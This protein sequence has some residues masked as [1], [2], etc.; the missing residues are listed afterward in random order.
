MKHYQAVLIYGLFCACAADPAHTAEVS[1]RDRLIE[2]GN[3]TL[4]V[5]EAHGGAFFSTRVSTG[6]VCHDDEQCLN[7]TVSWL[8]MDGGAEPLSSDR[9]TTIELGDSG[10]RARVQF[11]EGQPAHPR[12]GESVELGVELLLG[13]R[14]AGSEA[15]T[16]SAPL[17]KRVVETR[18]TSGVVQSTQET[19]YR[20][21]G[22]II[23][24][25][26]LL[27]TS[28]L[29]LKLPAVTFQE[30]AATALGQPVAGK[31]AQAQLQAICSGTQNMSVQFTSADRV[32]GA[33]SLLTARLGSGDASNLAFRLEYELDGSE[34]IVQWDGTPAMQI[35]SPGAVSIP[36]RAI[37]VRQDGSP[38]AGSVSAGG[39][40]TLYY[41]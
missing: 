41:N 12:A 13:D 26:C 7:Q 16:L 35:R 22:R 11:D 1:S 34:R 40:F 14:S 27:T 17:L 21:A 25:G 18:D 4:P 9:P 28:A 31:S 6:T 19:V 24:P 37:Y 23:T 15:F 5:G 10:L 30:I 3:V 20:L 33:P 36:V 39:S 29:S 38:S 8:A 2:L 32:S